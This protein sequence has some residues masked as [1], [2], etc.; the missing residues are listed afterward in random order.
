MRELCPRLARGCI[1]AHCH[2]DALMPGYWLVGLSVRYVYIL[3]I[4]LKA[5]KGCSVSLCIYLSRFELGDF[6]LNIYSSIRF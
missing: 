6:G 5:N 3:S 2:L 4:I 1:F